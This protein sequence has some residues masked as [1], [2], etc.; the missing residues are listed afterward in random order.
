MAVSM[1]KHDLGGSGS[2]GPAATKH[3]SS[4]RRRATGAPRAAAF[5]KL[6]SDVGDLRGR[7]SDIQLTLHEIKDTVC[8]L[9]AA[10]QASSSP[11]APPPDGAGAGDSCDPPTCSRAA[12]ATWCPASRSRRAPSPAAPSTPERTTTRYPVTPSAKSCR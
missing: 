12:D 7:V 11:G 9:L 3:A 5:D 2:D 6:Y 8:A 10:Q 1:P 4:H